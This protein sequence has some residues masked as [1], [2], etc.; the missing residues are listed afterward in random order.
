MK[1]VANS[2]YN[3]PPRYVEQY[4]IAL[5]VAH[6]SADGKLYENRQLDVAKVEELL[7]TSKVR[8]FPLG[9][10]AA[11]FVTALREL[12]A[13]G[14]ELLVVTSSRK[15]IGTYDAA[16]AATRTLAT[17]G[18]TRGNSIS[19]VDSQV[20]DA[21]VGLM[22][23]YCAASAK[24]GKDREAIAEA[25]TALGKRSLVEFVPRTLD[26][27]VA[28]GRASFV[29]A[30]AANLLQKVPI[31]SMID[32]ELTNTGTLSKHDDHPRVLAD[33]I[34]KKLGA[35]RQIWA[36]VSH[37]GDVEGARALLA[38]LRERF[39]VQFGFERELTPGYY[40]SCGPRCLVA[41]ILPIDESP[42][43]VET[44]S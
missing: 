27:L 30:L 39:D 38:N 44:P 3:I 13:D 17:L 8:P 15:V 16:V 40:L 10:S 36:A 34:A 7:R 19:I 25:A 35:K 23:I 18:V 29:K 2:G 28:G 20:A 31:I 41:H 12:V 37:G 11:E 21:A 33:I 32:G 14:S 43:S 1:I 6:V 5:T 42:W 4:G 9:T 24:A 26:Y 22:A